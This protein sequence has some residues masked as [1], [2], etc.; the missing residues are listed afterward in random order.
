MSFLSTTHILKYR[1]Q[2]ASI[3]S[4]PSS[5]YPSNLKNIVIYTPTSNFG[6]KTNN[7]FIINYIHARNFTTTSSTYLSSTPSTPSLTLP[8]DKKLPYGAPYTNSITLIPFSSS[9]TSSLP[10]NISQQ[11][12]TNNK[13]YILHIQIPDIP[14]TS[15]YIQDSSSSTSS[16]TPSSSSSSSSNTLLHTNLHTVLQAIATN[17]S[18]S[19]VSLLLN[20]YER[21]TLNDNRLSTLTMQDLYNR[22]LDLEINFIRWNVNEGNKLNSKGIIHNIKKDK[23]KSKIFWS[24]VGTISLIFSLVLWQNVIPDEHRRM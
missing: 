18:T 19:S 9:S 12:I 3:I 14:A 20:G 17:Y 22:S 6:T 16:S 7:T 1:S 8:K 13:L 23:W 24:G 5:I 21:Y 10:S 11:L 2:Y 15:Y 4:R